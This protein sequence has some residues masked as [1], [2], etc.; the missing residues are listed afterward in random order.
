MKENKFVDVENFNVL[1][2]IRE[3]LLQVTGII[4]K[5]FIN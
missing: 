1:D 4:I 3:R 2:A 5:I